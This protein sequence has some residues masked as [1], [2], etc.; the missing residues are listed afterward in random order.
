MAELSCK[1]GPWWKYLISTKIRNGITSVQLKYLVELIMFRLK[2]RGICQVFSVFCQKH[3]SH[4]KMFPPKP[5]KVS[6]SSARM[7]FH[8]WAETTSVA[9]FS[10]LILFFSSRI[11]RS[12][13]SGEI[14]VQT[15]SYRVGSV[16]V[17]VV[18][19]Y[20]VVMDH[21]QYIIWFAA[22]GRSV[23]YFIATS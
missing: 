10:V 20:I 21:T 15:Q 3:Q 11:M 2:S 13:V 17:V 8:V 9:K 23:F 5:Q 19:V 6:A 16:G 12:F 18:D 22:L 14:K 4:L 7:F 1:H